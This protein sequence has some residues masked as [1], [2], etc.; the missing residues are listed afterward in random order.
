V[1]IQNET[2]Q[3]LLTFA[4]S[5]EIQSITFS[6]PELATGEYTLYYGGRAD[7]T[8]VDGLYTDGTYAAGTEY[9][10]FTISSVTT[11]LGQGGFR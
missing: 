11:I 10:A 4:P 7:G 3:S 2:G 5:K 1:N 8:S 9:T 6:S